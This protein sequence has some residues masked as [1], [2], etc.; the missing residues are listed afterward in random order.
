MDSGLVANVGFT[1][2]RLEMNF[3]DFTRVSVSCALDLCRTSLLTASG[4]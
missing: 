4:A 2:H 1:Q 3:S